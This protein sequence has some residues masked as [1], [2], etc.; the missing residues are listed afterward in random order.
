MSDNVLIARN[1]HVLEIT[2]NKPKVNA[3]DNAMS[4]EL[5]DA[6]AEFDKNDDLRVAILTASGEKIFSAGWDLKALDKG[7]AQLDEWWND[8]D[9]LDI[10]K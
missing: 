10:D 1:E 5:A 2:L 8:D 7:D 6:F 4:K 9:Y 3:I